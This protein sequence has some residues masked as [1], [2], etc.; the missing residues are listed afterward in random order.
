M[1]AATPDCLVENYRQMISDLV[2]PDPDDRHVLAA[3]IAGRAD[4]IVTYNLKD[5]P[6]AALEPHGIEAQ[7]PD[8]FLIHQRGLGEQAFL[9]CARRCR[10]RLANPQFSPD[11]YLTALRKVG[12]V[13]VAAELEKTKGL[14]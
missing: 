2:L 6:L 8:T 4:V 12:L 13:L 9:E 7:H 10:R 5:F 11:D 3:A 1:D 14:L